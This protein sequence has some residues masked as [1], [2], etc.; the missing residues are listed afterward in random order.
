MDNSKKRRCF[1]CKTIECNRWTCPRPIDG[2]EVTRNK[3]A[4]TKKAVE[5]QKDKK[6]PLREHCFTLHEY[7]PLPKWRPPSEEEYGKRVINGKSLI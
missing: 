3:R 5:E 6:L 7:L 1:N 4:F 2:A